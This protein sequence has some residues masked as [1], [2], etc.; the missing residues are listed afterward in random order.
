[1]Q[2]SFE[3]SASTG[4]Y[5][6]TVGDQLLADVVREHPNAVY[7]VDT[8]LEDRLPPEAKRRIRVDALEAN[9]SLEYAPHLISELR[10]AGADRSTHLVAI[11]GGI[12][13]D[14]VTFAASIFMRGLPWTYMPTTLLSMV[15]SCIGGK[16]SIN[17]AGYKNLVGNFY[18][19]KKVLVDVSFI[20]TLDAEMIAG[21]LFE[22]AKICYASNYQAFLDY[23][24]CSPG[25]KMTDEQAVNVIR[26]SLLTKKWFIEID[27]FDQKER[28]LL[29][30]GHTFGHA[31]EAATDFGISHGI[32]VGLGM[33]VAA[34]YAKRET[35]LT[36]A[37][38]DHVAH[39]IRHVKDMIGPRAERVLQSPAHVDLDLAME[40]FEFDK[41]HKSDSYRIVIPNREGALAL[42]S[43]SKTP[44]TR[45]KILKAFSAAFDEMSWP[46]KIPQ[47][48]TPA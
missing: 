40:K 3:V 6:V 24:G 32:G 13:Q 21:G 28:L 33:L 5:A 25:L 16:S 37:G 9:K 35:E 12:I 41:K 30:F 42:V 44:E 27:E 45:L 20:S 22:A 2:D 46:Y 31:L 19:P 47:V 11:G 14:V 15:D 26:H 4:T 17:A 34:Q 23:L 10:K 7:I 48:V 18:P 43:V 39:L 38:K 1:M 8:I 29:N 36:D